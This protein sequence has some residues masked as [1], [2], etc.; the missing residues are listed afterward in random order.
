MVAEVVR[1]L[2]D[3]V[4][5]LLATVLPIAV[6]TLLGYI[7]G[8]R[9]LKYEHLHERRAEVIAGLSERLVV[10]EERIAD[11]WNVEETDDERRENDAKLEDA[12][13]RLSNYYRPNE[14]WLAPATCEKVD[15]FLSNAI[16][17]KMRRTPRFSDAQLTVHGSK[18]VRVLSEKTLAQA[19]A[20]RE[21]LIAEF[22][23]ILY[24]PPWYDAPLRWLEWLET[25]VRK[26]R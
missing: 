1:C 19:K 13:S 20:L 3:A 24:P 17:H 8:N 5:P 9:R 10:V 6:G 18:E 11:T 14:V 16:L 21:E 7:V 22:R 12:F 26:E 4:A 15:L 23:E 2:M 25:R